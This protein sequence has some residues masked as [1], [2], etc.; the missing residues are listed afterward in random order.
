[1]ADHVRM[2]RQ[3]EHTPFFICFIEL[4]APDA[5]YLI[6]SRVRTKGGGTVHPEVG[7]VIHYPLDGKLN[8]SSRSPVY[9]Y[10]V[11]PVVGHQTAV[12]EQPKLAHQFHRR[13][14]EVPRWCSHS[15]RLL[16]CDLCE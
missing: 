15:N 9:Q 16:A 12:V 14:T 6:R 4:R 10:L 3:D 8:H 2:H 1:M 11:R 5:E 7:E 13:R